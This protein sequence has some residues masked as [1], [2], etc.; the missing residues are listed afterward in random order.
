[1]ISF[2]H[3]TWDEVEHQMDLHRYAA[4]CR[5]WRRSPPLQRMV[6]A[7]LGIE[8]DE[9]AAPSVPLAPEDEQAAI[10]EFIR[11]FAAA[12]GTVN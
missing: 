9:A 7:Y 4:I 12:G 10:D 11:N 6:Q 3:W 5:H 1:M 2:T 8:P